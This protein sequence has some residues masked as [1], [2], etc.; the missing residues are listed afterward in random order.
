MQR[1]RPSRKN[2]FGSVFVFA[3]S[4]YRHRYN[5]CAVGNAAGKFQRGK[6]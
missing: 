2:E 5:V 4:L 6:E 1:K 3:C